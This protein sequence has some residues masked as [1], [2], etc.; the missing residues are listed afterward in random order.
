LDPV[1]GRDVI[2]SERRQ[3]GT[4]SITLGEDRRVLDRSPSELLGVSVKQ[5]A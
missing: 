2:G 3:D 1:L 4:R 5:F